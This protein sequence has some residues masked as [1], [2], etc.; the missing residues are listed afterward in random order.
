MVLERT[1]LELSSVNFWKPPTMACP[2][3][4]SAIAS[5]IIFSASTELPPVSVLAPPLAI[6][7]SFPVTPPRLS[8]VR[9]GQP[10]RA[11]LE[12]VVPTANSS[13]VPEMT[14]V[15]IVPLAVGSNSTTKET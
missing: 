7:L 14:N 13:P 12:A 4:A 8:I 6:D 15:S 10:I 2:R 9:F 3:V 5:S 1:L 11:V